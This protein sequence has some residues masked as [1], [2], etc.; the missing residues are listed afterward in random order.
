MNMSHIVKA[1]KLKLFAKFH[2]DWLKQM[3][4]GQIMQIMSINTSFITSYAC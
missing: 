1:T 2:D 3:Q 4:L